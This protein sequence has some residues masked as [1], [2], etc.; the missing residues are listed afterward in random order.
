MVRLDGRPQGRIVLVELRDPLDPA[1]GRLDR[2]AS[3]VYFENEIQFQNRRVALDHPRPHPETLRNV[4]PQKEERHMPST[5]TTAIDTKKVG[6]VLNRILELELAGIVRYLHYSFMVFG[7]H[8]IPICAWLRAQADESKVHALAAGEKITSLGE[9][10][11][12][13]IGP[14]LETHK[15]DVNSILREAA[16]HESEAV[17]NYRELLALVAGKDVRLEEYARTLIAEEEDHLCEI[18]KMLRKE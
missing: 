4:N 1:T 10:P 5:G 14:L 12:L 13:A 2:A 17:K 7:H 16:A 11:S 9:H 18:D 3:I 15:H 6:K 8:R